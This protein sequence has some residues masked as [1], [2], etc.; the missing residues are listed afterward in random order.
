MQ[1]FVK[2]SA[3]AMA[4]CL[5]P[6]LGSRALAAEGGASHY[7][8]GTAGDIALAVASEPG[9][10]VANTF[11]FQSGDVGATVLEGAVRFGVDADVFLNLAYGAY[12][13]DRSVLGGRYT[14]G[15]LVPFGHTKID[16]STVGPLGGR[17]ASSDTSFDLSD[18]AII[19]VQLNWNSGNFH[20]KL[21]EA[22]IAPSGGYDVDDLA[23][24]GRNH[25]SFDTVGAA[26]WLNLE[27]GTEISVAPGIMVNTT[28]NAT[29]YKTG[30]EFHLDFTAN[31]F[32]SPGFA[33]GLRGYWYEQVTGDSGS[34][35]RL[36]DF[37][38]SSFGIGPGFVWTPTAAQGRLNIVGKWLHDLQADKRLKSDYGTLAVAWTF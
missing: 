29:D 1:D 4:I 32:L 13:F 11:W 9:L 16:A 21:A 8:P 37:K 34:G 12:T 25:W 17:I 20:F 23:N 28:N 33:V 38:S 10:Q 27:T 14:I 30:A 6:A 31:Q 18:I 3:M 36:G 26:T 2:T 5:A 7:L 22:I 35:A 19:P 24:L 15:A